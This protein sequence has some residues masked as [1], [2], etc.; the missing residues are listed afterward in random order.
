MAEKA[1]IKTYGCQMNEHDS[2]QMRGVL[3]QQGYEITDDQDSASLIVVN[4]CSVRHNP[5]NKVYSLVGTLRERKKAEPNLIIAVAGCVAQ[6][7][8]D[9]ILKRDKSIDMVFGPDNFF[10]LPEMIE[11]VKAGERV[12]N[13]KWMPRDHKIQNFIPEEWIER[14]HVEGIKAYIA[15]TKGCNNM[16]TYCIVPFTR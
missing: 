15:I 11:Q 3:E 12:C 8:G 10:K 5:E 2:F 16:C 4:T 14:G 7:E 1:Y 6:Q 13:T 9:K